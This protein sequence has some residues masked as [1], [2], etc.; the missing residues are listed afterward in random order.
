MIGVPPIRWKRKKFIFIAICSSLF[1]KF[2]GKVDRNFFTENISILF[3]K[4]VMKNVR[5]KLATIRKPT[6]TFL[7]FIK[8]Q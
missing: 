2:T 1:Y 7:K 5:V 6:N 8:Y 4:N 3:I